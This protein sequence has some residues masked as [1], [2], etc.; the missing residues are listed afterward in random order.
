MGVADALKLP[1]KHQKSTGKHS[2]YRATG[3]LCFVLLLE[4]G[5]RCQH[6]R[7]WKELPRSNSILEEL[8]LLKLYEIALEAQRTRK[9]LKI[10]V[11]R[12]FLDSVADPAKN[13]TLYFTL[14]KPCLP[15]RNISIC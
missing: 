14:M 4:H 3:Y 7:K 13:L 15:G 6:L 1:T 9:T 11:S 12:T 2:S 10:K 8:S 5:S